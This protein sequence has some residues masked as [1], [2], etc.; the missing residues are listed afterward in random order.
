M[1]Q[2]AEITSNSTPG[3]TDNLKVIIKQT[4]DLS[5]AGQG[6]GVEGF[7]YVRAIGIYQPIANPI[8]PVLN[9]FGVTIDGE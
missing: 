4:T 5:E 6:T 3:F 1:A 7:E 8:D 2:H 9:R